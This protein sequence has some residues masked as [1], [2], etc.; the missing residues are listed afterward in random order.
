MDERIFVL[1][2]V[3]SGKSATAEH[4]AAGLAAGGPVD[5]LATAEPIPGDDQWSARIEAHRARRPAQWV[6]IETRDVAVHLASAGA[7]LLV[8]SV[9]SWLA[10]TMSALGCFD[11]TESDAAE[12]PGALTREIDALVAAWTATMRP[13][14]A[15]SDEIG[16]GGIGADGVTRRFADELGALNQRLAAAADTVLLVVAGQVLA[17]KGTRP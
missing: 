11:A 7:P 5:Y 17:V 3:R 8:E 1:G 2:G 13:A 4:L 10:G 14:V 12:R 16:L 6:T 9:T 15:V